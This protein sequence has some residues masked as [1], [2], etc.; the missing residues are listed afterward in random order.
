MSTTTNNNKL[1]TEKAQAVS[2]VVIPIDN[3]QKAFEYAIGLCERKRRDNTTVASQADSSSSS[4]DKQLTIA[5]PALLAD[6]FALLQNHC[7]ASNIQ[8]IG[9]NLRNYLNGVDVGF[10]YAD[11]G[12]AETGTLVINST[13]EDLRL[14]TM[15]SDIHLAILP[16]SRIKKDDLDLTSELHKLLADPKNFT[17]FIT[18]PSRTAD[19]ERVLAIGV[20]GPLELHILLLEDGQ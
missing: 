2:A 16:T 11:Y 8:I 12:I 4:K 20:H 14:A 3:M 6:D 18:G 5:A 7:M 19:I 13:S 10:T 15:I 1:F 17:A 9:N